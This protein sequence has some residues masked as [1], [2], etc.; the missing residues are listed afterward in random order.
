LMRDMPCNTRGVPDSISH[1]LRV[2]SL[3]C[4]SLDQSSPAPD[5]PFMSV[6]AFAR[7][8]AGRVII[9]SGQVKSPNY[10]A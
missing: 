4:R 2:P 9:S 5:F 7:Q 3:D 10:M 6:T 1:S 8:C